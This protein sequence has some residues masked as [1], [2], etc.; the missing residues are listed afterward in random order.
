MS[1]TSSTFSMGDRGYHKAHVGCDS[2][3]TESLR[4]L[5]SL[6]AFPLLRV[7]SAPVQRFEEPAAECPVQE[8]SMISIR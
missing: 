6:A 1:K 7:G 5:D 4:A 3:S 2:A 8:I